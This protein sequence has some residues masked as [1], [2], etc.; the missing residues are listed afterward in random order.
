[1]APRQ[2]WSPADIRELTAQALTPG[3]RE[4]LPQALTLPG[5]SSWGAT[6]QILRMTPWSRR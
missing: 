1:M 2:G 3:C 6:E 4:G 5:N